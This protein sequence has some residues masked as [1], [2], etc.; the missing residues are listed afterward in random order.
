MCRSNLTG[1]TISSRR[2]QNIVGRFLEGC[3]SHAIESDE[4]K[5]PRFAIEYNRNQVIPHQVV[6]ANIWG[7]NQ[8]VSGRITSNPVESDELKSVQHT[9]V[10]FSSI[11]IDSNNWF[12]SFQT[13]QVICSYGWFNYDCTFMPRCERENCMHMFMARISRAIAQKS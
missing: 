7:L 4:I 6:E 2:N 10:W 9:P 5:L 8:I 12:I 3:W 11:V 13:M 1:H